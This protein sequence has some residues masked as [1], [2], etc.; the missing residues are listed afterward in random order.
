MTRRIFS[1]ITDL[2]LEQDMANNIRR[3]ALDQKFL[4]IGEGAAEAYYEIINTGSNDGSQGFGPE[5]NYNFLKQYI[6]T[7]EK[8]AII[9]LGCGDSSPEKYLLDNLHQNSYDITYFGIDIS[10]SMLRKAEE[11]LLKCPVDKHMIH[12]DISQE[13]FKTELQV[14]TQNYDKRIFVFLGGTF[15]NNNQ[16]EITDILYNILSPNDLLWLDVVVRPSLSKLDDMK[17]FSRYAAWLADKNRV[18]QFFYRSLKALGIPFNS[19][20]FHLSTSE[21]PSIGT[22]LSTFSFLLKE[23]VSINLLGEDIYLLPNENIPILNIRAYHPETL[24]NFLRG[25]NFKLIEQR[26]KARWGQFMFCKIGKDK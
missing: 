21:E 16:T 17:I 9:S 6:K 25:H 19:G 4:Y 18:Q 15:A 22:L 5:D 13:S 20:E 1:L 14:L 26:S 2:K 12:A 24:V 8:V 7:K 3:R 11:D 23:K 10:R